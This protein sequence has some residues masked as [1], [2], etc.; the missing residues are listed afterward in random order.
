MNDFLLIVCNNS[1]FMYNNIN[2]HHQYG[3][4]IYKMYTLQIIIKENNL[5]FA[6]THDMRVMMGCKYYT[7][8]PGIM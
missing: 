2:I 5:F 4:I 8:T 7:G 1:T 6:S 3:S